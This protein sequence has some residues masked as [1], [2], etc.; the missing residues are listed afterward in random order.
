MKLNQYQEQSLATALYRQEKFIVSPLIY[1]TLGLAGETGELVEKIKKIIRDNG[2]H[3]SP[4]RRQAIMME[5]GD[6]LWYLANLTNELGF[7]LEEVAEANLKKLSSRHRRGK[8]HGS[9]DKR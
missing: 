9:G 3:L 2:G 5:A 7:S 1:L 4:K 6:I 8:T